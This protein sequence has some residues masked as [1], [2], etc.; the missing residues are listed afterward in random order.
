MRARRFALATVLAV[1]VVAVG[2]AAGGILTVAPPVRVSG[3]S[4]FASCTNI[5]PGTPGAVNYVNSEVEP[6]VAVNPADPLN[7][8]GVWQQDRWSDGG[9]RGL[10]TGYSTERRCHLEH[11]FCEV[12]V[13]LGR[14]GRERG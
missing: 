10:A 1:S 3:P 9:A 11:D 13:L 7:I 6:W 12:H 4:P 5:G 2:V 14:D 8:V